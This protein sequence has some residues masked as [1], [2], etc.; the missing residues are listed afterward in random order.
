MEYMDTLIEFDQRTGKAYLY[1]GRNRGDVSFNMN[2][3][4]L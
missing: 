4:N 3:F 1:D 2:N